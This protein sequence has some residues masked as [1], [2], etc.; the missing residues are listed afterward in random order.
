[1]EAPWRVC[2]DAMELPLMVYGM[3]RPWLVHC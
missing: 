3:V 2:G 1:M